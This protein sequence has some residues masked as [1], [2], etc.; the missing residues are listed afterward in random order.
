[1]IEIKKLLGAAFV[2]MALQAAGQNGYIILNE[3][4]S[5][6][7]GYL[8]SFRTVSSGEQGIEVW[9]N[10]KDK[11][12]LKVL[13]TQLFEYAIKE[14]TFRVFQEFKPFHTTDTY[15]NVVDAK[16]IS[17]GKVNLFIIEDYVNHERISTYT[18]GGII[19]AIIDANMGN[20]NYMYILE[21][22]TTGNLRALSSK[23]EALW[24]TLR[25]FFPDQYLLKYEEVKGPIK[26]Q[27]IPALVKLYN[28]K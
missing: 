18:G 10:K 24:E 27:N 15:F 20:F 1:M 13:K 12:P 11:H 26:Y 2:L 28:S 8:K 7:S 5:V 6:I 21:H 9:R 4:D 22:N 25:D 16:L 23:K 19:P 17:R 3:T 14:D